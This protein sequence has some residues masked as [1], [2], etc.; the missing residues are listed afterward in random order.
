MIFKSALMLITGFMML[1]I[2][3]I[4]SHLVPMGDYED[5]IINR[6]IGDLNRNLVEYLTIYNTQDFE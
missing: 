1:I 2:S 3:A 4:Y 6:S 5:R